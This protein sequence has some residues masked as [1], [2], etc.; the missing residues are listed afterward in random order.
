MTVSLQGSFAIQVKSLLP[1]RIKPTILS[2]VGKKHPEVY[3]NE[4]FQQ[5]RSI[6]FYVSIAYCTGFGRLGSKE[7][8]R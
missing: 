3:T 6:G 2:A 1:A 5:N 8:W 7:G 4:M